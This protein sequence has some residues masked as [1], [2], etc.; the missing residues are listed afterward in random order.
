MKA[1]YAADDVMNLM[2]CTQRGVPRVVVPE[3]NPVHQRGRY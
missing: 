1:E 2:L 3:Y